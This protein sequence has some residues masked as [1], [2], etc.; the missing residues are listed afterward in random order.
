MPW[1]RVLASRIVG[2]LSKR[3]PEREL[4]EELRAHEEQIS[5]RI[6]REA[7][8]AASSSSPAHSASRRLESTSRPYPTGARAMSMDLSRSP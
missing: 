6:R 3:R 5:T 8:P 2:L 7:I 1:L 4:D